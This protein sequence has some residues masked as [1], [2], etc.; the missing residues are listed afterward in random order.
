M[1]QNK[2][3]PCKVG[4][5]F[6]IFSKRLLYLKGFLKQTVNKEDDWNGRC[7][8]PVGVAGQMRPRRQ[9]EEAHRPPHGKRASWNGNLHY[10]MFNSNKVYEN[11]LIL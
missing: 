10:S 3:P 9:A 8:T 5:Y 6:K 4:F 2:N 11:N 1:D 7:E